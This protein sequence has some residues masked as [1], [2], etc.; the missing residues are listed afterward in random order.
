MSY[1]KKI[2]EKQIEEK[3]GIK[4]PEILTEKV[5]SFNQCHDQFTKEIKERAD[6]AKLHEI[7]YKTTGEDISLTVAKGL[8]GE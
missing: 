6:E 8:G 1:P 5:I 2:N 7:Y 3:Y 4:N